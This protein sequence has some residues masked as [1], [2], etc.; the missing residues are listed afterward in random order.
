[1]TK[2]ASSASAIVLTMGSDRKACHK[3]R[4]FIVD[5]PKRNLP[6]VCRRGAPLDPNITGFWCCRALQCKVEKKRPNRILRLHKRGTQ[7][8]HEKF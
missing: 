8:A 1:M 4:T 7:Y 6:A 3:W 5:A 2:S